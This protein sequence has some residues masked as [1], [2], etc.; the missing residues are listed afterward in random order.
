MK[1]QSAESR[2]LQADLS[3]C[4]QLPA[5]G[6][7][8][9]PLPSQKQACSCAERQTP[10]V[11]SQLWCACGVPRSPCPNQGPVPL[12]GGVSATGGA[13]WMGKCH[14]VTQS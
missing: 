5:V 6:R 13:A 7:P 11:S 12:L 2:Y 10:A 4:T 8:V 9:P 1:Q 3:A 14:A